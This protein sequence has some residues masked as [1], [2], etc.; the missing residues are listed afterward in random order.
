MVRLLVLVVVVGCSVPDVS[1]EG[2]MC[3]CVTG[4]SCG[5]DGF[6][7]GGSGGSGDGGGTGGCL[8]TLAGG[9]LYTA[10]F[11]GT[12]VVFATDGG[13]WMQGGQLSQSAT[14]VLTWAYPTT[15]GTLDTTNYRVVSKM[16][17]VTPGATAAGLGIAVHIA[18]GAKT[19]YDCMWEPGGTN[20]ALIWQYLNP[21]GNPTTIGTPVVGALS[22]TITM[23]VLIT[24][25]TTYK[26]CI[27][28]NSA[29]NEMSNPS[30]AYASGLPGVATSN[31]HAVFQTFYVTQN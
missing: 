28:E 20:G 14:N 6:C 10:D 11:S 25:G 31:M 9:P 1:L 17:P 3:P 13:M 2:K 27:D 29:M 4:Y 23:R 24:N 30:P 8:G 12:T 15:P 19:Q 18:N 26:C 22:S 5:S 16:M 7:H 21:G